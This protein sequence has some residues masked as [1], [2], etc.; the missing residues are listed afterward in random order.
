MQLT[1]DQLEIPL[2]QTAALFTRL[3]VRTPVPIK[4]H[5]TA[6]RLTLRSPKGFLETHAKSE[7]TATAFLRHWGRNEE[8][9]AWILGR[10]ERKHSTFKPQFIP[11]Q[12]ACSWFRDTR[13]LAAWWKESRNSSGPSFVIPHFAGMFQSTQECKAR[14]GQALVN[15]RSLIVIE[16]GPEPPGDLH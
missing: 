13:T 7:L 4:R 9:P 12:G 6:A 3:T 10:Q 15:Y 16:S 8:T 11:N 5:A 2:P 14:T 1:L